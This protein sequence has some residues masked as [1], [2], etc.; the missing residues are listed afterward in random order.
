MLFLAARTDIRIPGSCREQLLMVRE[1]GRF[2]DTTV[3]RG[4]MSDYIFLSKVFL[5]LLAPQAQLVRRESPAVMGSQGRQA[6]RV[7]QVSL[8]PASQLH[9]VPSETAR[10]AG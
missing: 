4:S 6:R 1:R 2:S 5:G 9:V 7:N 3:L 10:H 8:V